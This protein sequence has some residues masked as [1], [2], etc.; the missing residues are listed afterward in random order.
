MIEYLLLFIAQKHEII[1]RPEM[2]VIC[3]IN[4]GTTLILKPIINELNLEFNKSVSIG[5]NCRKNFLKFFR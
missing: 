3:N 1:L 5:I 2:L 4:T